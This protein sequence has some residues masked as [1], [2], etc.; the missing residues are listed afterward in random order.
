M[1]FDYV[2]YRICNFYQNYDKDPDLMAWGVLSLVQG[3]ML[4]NIFW[5]ISFLYHFPVKTNAVIVLILLPLGLNLR[6]YVIN[7]CYAK[8]K[9][10]WKDENS[11]KNRI[12]GWLVIIFIFIDCFILPFA[13]PTAVPQ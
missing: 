7:S 2:F 5:M 12:R 10:R 11:A 8:L 4:L 3:F 9:D 1:F 6:K 13:I